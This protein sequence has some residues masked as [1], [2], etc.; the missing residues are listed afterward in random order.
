MYKYL[1]HMNKKKFHLICANLLD[2]IVLDHA[3]GMMTL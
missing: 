1:K 2:K 3:D